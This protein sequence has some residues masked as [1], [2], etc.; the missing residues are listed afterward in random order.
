MILKTSCKYWFTA[1]GTLLT[2][3]L[4]CPRQ[5]REKAACEVTLIFVMS[6]CLSVGLSVC[7]SVRQFCPEPNSLNCWSILMKL[8]HNVYG[9]I[10]LCPPEDESRPPPR[11]RVT[12]EKHAFW[13]CF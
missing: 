7:L 3:R 13:G 12:P 8:A 1:R 4:T 9:V 2:L 6:V 5:N 11:G 10:L